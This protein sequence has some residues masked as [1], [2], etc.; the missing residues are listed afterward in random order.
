MDRKDVYSL[1]LLAGG[2]SLRMGKDK[3]RLLYG[4]KTFAELIIDK[5]KEVGID[6]IFVSGFE[7][8]GDVGEVVWDR[9]PD[10]GPLGGLHACMKEMETPFC[11]VLPVDVPRLSPEILEELLVYHE[12]HR[13]GLTRGREIPLL[14]EHGVRKE[15]LIGVYPVAMA[16][17]IEEMIKERALPVFRVLDRWGYECFLRDIPEDQILNV[18]TPELYKRLLES[19]PD[20][21]AE[22][23]GGKMEKERV[24]ILKITGNQF[25]EK[26]DDVALEYQYCLRLKDGREISI[27]CTPTHMEELSLGRRFLLGDL[28]GEIKPVHADP[29]ESISLKKIFQAAKEMFENPGT[30]FSDTGCAHSCVLMME[31]RV[32]CSMEDIGRHNALD[33]VIGYALKYEIP[34]PKCAVFSSGRISQDYLQKAI[35]AGFSVVLSR[36]AVTGSA[37]ALA[38]KEDITLLGFIRKEAGNI[39]H[40]GHVKISEK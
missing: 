8:E 12:R 10:R 40:M 3:A 7:L 17:T 21:T 16:E 34:I 30:L 1:L 35:Q 22:G 20:G 2:K 13:R 36:A 4:G 31:G 5:A 27:S 26:E 18:N 37:V 15:P 25:Q 28:A 24:Q 29:V 33:K 39:Y 14:W 9:Y 6:R 11:L 38:K 32:L 23:R 19:R